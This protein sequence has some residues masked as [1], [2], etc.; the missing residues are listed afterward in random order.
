M[1]CVPTPAFEA[2]AIAHTDSEAA[3]D[4]AHWNAEVGLNRELYCYIR[5]NQQYPSLSVL[6]FAE[7]AL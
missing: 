1:H 2:A 4:K 6:R 5:C 3:I 7:T